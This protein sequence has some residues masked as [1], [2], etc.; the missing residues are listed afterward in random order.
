MHGLFVVAQATA[1]HISDIASWTQLGSST[2]V[3]ILVI[4]LVTYGIPR[5][6]Q[7]LMNDF[8]AEREADRQA[9]HT[10]ANNF[11]AALAEMYEVNR[12]DHEANRAHIVENTKAITGL[13]L[14]IQKMCRYQGQGQVG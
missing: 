11:N 14:A 5:M 10:A 12:A 2:V 9:R 8:R 13:Q 6:F 7:G 3:S 1:P 4:W